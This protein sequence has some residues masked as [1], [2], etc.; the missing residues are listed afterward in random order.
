MYFR[1]GVSKQTFSYLDN[2]TWW[3]IYGWLRKRH[4]GLNKGTLVKRFLPDWE[5]RDGR[6][7]LFRP[8]RV[9]IT[10]YRYRG[11]KIPSPWAGRAS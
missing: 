10:R 4:A 1:H 7:E 2:F 3:R 11:G 9:P 8:M 6:V 5:I